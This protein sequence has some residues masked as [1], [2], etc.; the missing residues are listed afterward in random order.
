MDIC[1][2]QGVIWLYQWTNDYINLCGVKA[3]DLDKLLKLHLK[4][5][6]ESRNHGVRGC[7]FEANSIRFKQLWLITRYLVPVNF[8]QN[9][10]W[11][12]FFY[13]L[14]SVSNQF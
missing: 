9:E 7:I 4:Q 6:T 2:K 12:R 3:G 5:I 10:L 11:E 1:V 13:P 14:K 8:K